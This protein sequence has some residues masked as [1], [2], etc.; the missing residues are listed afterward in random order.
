MVNKQ[1]AFTLEDQRS[2]SLSDAD[3]QDFI[4]SGRT[5]IGRS[6]VSAPLQILLDGGYLSGPGTLLHYGKGRTTL[7][8][9]A[10]EEV[11]LTVF[12][13]D[14]V[15]CPSPELLGSCYSVIFCCYVV[16]TLPRGSRAHVY[17]Q[18]AYACGGTVFIAA[19]SDRIKGTPCLLY[20]SPSPRD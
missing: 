4:I 10:M 15:H 9:P 13:Y 7:D 5:A 14:Y 1:L 16:N 18:L 8:S 20:T 2:P 3:L 11:G 6:K 17:R 19:R 12:D